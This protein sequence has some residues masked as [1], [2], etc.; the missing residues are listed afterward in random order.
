M[1]TC[2]SFSHKFSLPFCLFKHEQ[3][4]NPTLILVHLTNDMQSYDKLFKGICFLIAI[5]L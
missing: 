3:E 5:S 4:Q 2:L 1:L